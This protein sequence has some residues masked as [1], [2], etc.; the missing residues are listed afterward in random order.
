MNQAEET[1]SMANVDSDRALDAPSQ[2][3][4]D[5]LTESAGESEIVSHTVPQPVKIP[6]R[7]GGDDDATINSDNYPAAAGAASVPPTA[8]GDDDTDA[9]KRTKD[10]IGLAAYILY[11]NFVESTQRN[12]LAS[13]SSSTSAVDVSVDDGTRSDVPLVPHS[14]TPT[15]LFPRF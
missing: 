11:R 4:T 7:E 13:L 6:S 15:R 9:D 3:S 8:P 14:T 12:D 1:P 5:T 2:L 10:E